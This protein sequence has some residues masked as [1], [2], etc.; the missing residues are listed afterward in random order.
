VGSWDEP[1]LKIA[2]PSFIPRFPRQR[3]AP[4]R[5]ETRASCA[6]PSRKRRERGRRQ[7]GRPKRRY[8]PS[9]AAFPPIFAQ[10]PQCDRAHKQGKRSA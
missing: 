6:A 2:A 8:M 7:P 9:S 5:V 3:S 1:V 4:T 10:A